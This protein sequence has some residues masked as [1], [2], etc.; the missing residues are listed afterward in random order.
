[1]A[2]E[3][4]VSRLHFLGSVMGGMHVIKDNINLFG[5]DPVASQQNLSNLSMGQDLKCYEWVVK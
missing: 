4:A 3:K 5:S 2:N 1:M